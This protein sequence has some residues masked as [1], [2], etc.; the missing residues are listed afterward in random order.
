MSHK[1]VIKKD[2]E[3]LKENT[4]INE[5]IN[6]LW[7]I[8]LF[9]A[10][11]NIV[12]PKSII[13]KMHDEG[14]VLSRIPNAYLKLLPIIQ[15]L[16]YIIKTGYI[17]LDVKASNILCKDDQLTLIDFELCLKL[18]K[19]IDIYALFPENTYYPILPPEL[20]ISEMTIGKYNEYVDQYKKQLI[21]IPFQYA[22]DVECFKLTKYT[23]TIQANI[24]SIG[25]LLYNL[26]AKGKYLELAEKCINVDPMK[27]PT[28][29]DIIQLF[30]A[31]S[32]QSTE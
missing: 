27:R 3:V 5:I 8:N 6:E 14:V 32:T 25:I 22:T 19:N 21:T 20:Y 15:T 7:F 4:D 28:Y 31:S 1:T 16:H 11:P 29:P 24:W 13:I 12:Q 2:G 30:E 10:I 17:Y 26:D 23:M 18:T 9:S